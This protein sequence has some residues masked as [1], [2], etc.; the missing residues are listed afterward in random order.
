[1]SDNKKIPV[2]ALDAGHW[3][4]QAGRRVWKI[5][6][7]E[8]T[9]EWVINNRVISHVQKM[10]EEY[11]CKVI[12]LDDPDG[13]T[14]ISLHDRVVQANNQKA[15]IV[16]S[17]HHNGAINGGSGGGL[18]VFRYTDTKLSLN[19]QKLYD[20]ILARTG[21]KGNR[22]EPTPEANFYILKKTNMEAYLI[23]GGFM[24]SSV[25]SKII[26]TPEYAYKAAIGIVDFLK[27]RFNL[28]KKPVVVAPKE[29]PL[30][31]GMYFRVVAL[32]AKYR[33]NAEAMQAK[34]KELGIDSFL[35]IFEKPEK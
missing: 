29:Q 21:L 32:S 35:A 11:E 6:D 24:D 9:R 14:L 16:I 10:L 34:L 31:E 12:R 27:W 22:S 30:P 17:Q 25:D 19:Y 20:S 8:E 33:S 1:M 18:V 4:Y 28:Q 5:F 26:I 15:D 13:L 23:E 3:L 2:I 7:S